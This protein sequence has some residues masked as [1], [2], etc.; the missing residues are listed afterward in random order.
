MSDDVGQFEK[1]IKKNVDFS[2]QITFF[3]NF[4]PICTSL[5]KC[6]AKPNHESLIKKSPIKYTWNFDG[7]RERE[8]HTHKS[9][10][11]RIYNINKK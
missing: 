10:V 3:S 1:R 5:K 9:A 7:M 8:R 11:V 2:F 4:F 6:L